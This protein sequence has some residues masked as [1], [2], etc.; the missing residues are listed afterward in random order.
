M[1]NRGLQRISFGPGGAVLLHSYYLPYYFQAVLD[2]S[3]IISSVHI[4]TYVATN[5]FIATAASFMAS[6]TGYFNPPAI[7]GPFISTIG[8]GLLSTLKPTTP[9]GKWAGYQI[10]TATGLGMAVQQVYVVAQA[11]LPK[12]Q[13][14]MGTAL[15]LFI[16]NLAG[17]V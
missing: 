9:T 16:Q 17:S 12:S 1:Y 2:N 3:A 14:P 15:M 10:L 13:G 8:C 7:L 11:V 5:Y 6:R 4:I